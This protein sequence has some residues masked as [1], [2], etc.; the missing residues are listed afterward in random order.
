ME[1]AKVRPSVTLFSLDR[2]LSNLVWL[3]LAPRWS[4]FYSY[5]DLRSDKGQATDRPKRRSKG[6]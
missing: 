3:S 4:V 2:S 5:A 1:Q 6:L